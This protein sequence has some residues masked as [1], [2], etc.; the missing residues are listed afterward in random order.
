MTE[1]T[2][3]KE[4]LSKYD[5]DQKLT[6]GMLVQLIAEVELDI[7]IETERQQEIEDELR[8]N[9]GADFD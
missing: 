4:I 2:R 6:F 8:S 7:E 3:L 1:L 9:I 5:R